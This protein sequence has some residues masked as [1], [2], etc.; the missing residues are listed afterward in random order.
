MSV[1]CNIKAKAKTMGA[2]KLG[3]LR[4]VLVA[5]DWPHECCCAVV[6]EYRHRDGDTIVCLCDHRCPFYI[7]PKDLCHENIM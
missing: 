7:D 6:C 4:A 5:G 3:N 1:P 2:K